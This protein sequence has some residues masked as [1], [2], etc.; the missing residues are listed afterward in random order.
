M[1]L[2]SKLL[3]SSLLATS[4]VACSSSGKKT[5]A[6]NPK[7]AGLP[8]SKKS[9]PDAGASIEAKQLAAQQQAPFVTELNFEKGESHL[10]HEAKA[11]VTKILKQA[12][13]KGQIEQVKLI[14]WADNEYPSVHT[15]VLPEKEKNLADSRN[16][17]I[18]SFI[19]SKGE[20]TPVIEKFN[21]A[22]RPGALAEMVGT[23]NARLKG[24]LEKAG[25][26]NTD[27][28]VKSPSKASKAIVMVILREPSARLHQ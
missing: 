13:E 6:E 23:E 17:E 28:S 24:T 14:S 10:S 7:E 25:I 1:K 8:V 16:R 18:E 9:A 5:E 26:P 3:M 19:A 11:R 20:T 2:I 4:L 12:G 15:K 21:M 22:E 27:T